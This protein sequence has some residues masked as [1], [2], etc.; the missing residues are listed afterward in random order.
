MTHLSV[1]LF[2]RLQEQKYGL[3][4][5]RCTICGR[6]YF[7]KR[8]QVCVACHGRECEDV[9]LSGN[10]RI[11]SW[12]VIRAAPNGFEAPYVI[13]VVEL[14]EGIMFTAPLA[15][16]PEDVQIGQRVRAAF[17]R[18]GENEG[19]MILYGPKFEVVG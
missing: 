5:S 9:K 10:G 12:T 3:M 14:D 19:G 18:L 6:L 4:A 16:Q 11:L 15:A 17:R 7:P 13:G 1:P 2:W 8:K